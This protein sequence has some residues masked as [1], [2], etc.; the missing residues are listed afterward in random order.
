MQATRE[1]EIRDIHS[2]YKDF[3]QI[4]GGVLL[5]CIGIW[6]GSLMFQDGYATNVYTEL[7]SV[8]VT[9][10]V[11]D[12]LNDW[13]ARNREREALQKRL[14]REASSSGQAVAVTALDWLREEGWLNLIQG[15]KLDHPNWECAY[16]GGLN[17]SEAN[18]EGA[19]LKGIISYTKDGDKDINHPIQLENANL[20]K[21]NLQEVN[22]KYAN[23][24]KANLEYADLEKANFWSA[25]LQEANFWS[26]NLQDANLQKANLQD[27]ILDKANLQKAD[28]YKANLQYT[29]LTLANLQYTNL[30]FANLQYTNL[31]CANLEKA[32]LWSTNLREAN[33]RGTN[34]RS[35]NLENTKF[36]KKTVLPDATYQGKDE[37]G[38]YLRDENG[39]YIYNKYWTPETDMSRYTDPN[40]PDFW[41]PD[42]VKEQRETGEG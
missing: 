28:M 4:G 21:A 30:A 38:N 37:G 8:V 20:K 13:R 5:V 15:D 36:D 35:A 14:L 29:D 10:L 18:F 11:L 16:V 23:L 34:L 1:E 17:L 7:M 12:R 32:D 3:Y 25:N 33:L 31:W 2:K 9:I 22:L 19:N 42:W 27:A 24:Q 39:N 26:A 40:H 41:E 6:I